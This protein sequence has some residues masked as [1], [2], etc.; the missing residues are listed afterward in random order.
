[1]TLVIGESTTPYVGNN[2]SLVCNIQLSG[3]LTTDD[4]SVSVKWLRNDIIYR[5]S[6]PRGSG[7]TLQSMLHFSPLQP[8]DSGSYICEVTVTANQTTY[9]VSKTSAQLN[10]TVP[11]EH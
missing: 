9:A 6:I 4:V 2:I 5:N 1:M 11:S 7:D 3:G 8:S 10:L